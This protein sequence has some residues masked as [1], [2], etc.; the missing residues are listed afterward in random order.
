[1]S[2]PQVTWDTAPQPKPEVTWDESP[3]PTLKPSHE[4]ID[5]SK[6]STALIASHMTGIP[7]SMAYQNHDQVQAEFA[8]HNIDA[9]LPATIANDIKVGSENSIFGLAYR[10]RL[11]EHLQAPGQFDE[12][13]AGLSTMVLDLPV[14][15]AGMT[16]GAAVGNVP[17]AAMGTFAV[18]AAIR[19]SLM[20]Q[21]E[22]G[23]IKSF[24]D[25][26]ERTL[27]VSYESTKGA[28]TGLVME[29]SGGATVPLKAALGPAAPAFTAVAKVAQQSA[30]LELLTSLEEG[31]MPT[32]VGIAKNA[33]LMGTLGLVAHGIPIAA[34]RGKQALMD[35]YAKDGTTPEQSATKLQA[36][37]SVK[38]DMP[39]GLKPAIMLKASD[40]SD[41]VITGEHNTHSDL[42]EAM[43]GQRPV[44]IDELEADP[45]LAD[46][47]LSQPRTHVQQVIDRAYEIKSQAGEPLPPKS[48]FKSGRGFTNAAGDYLPRNQAK[49]LVKE[50]EPDVYAKW[51]EITGDDKAEFHSADYKEARERVAA[52]KVAEGEP[53]VPKELA[54]F[55]A[56]I[57]PELNDIK[58]SNK[59]DGYGKEV[60][61][62]L[63]VGPRNSIRSNAEQ[64]VGR[65][66]ELVPDST[67]QQAISFMRD[68]RDDPGVLRTEI[69]DISKGDNEKLK[70]MIPA[71]EKALNPTPEMLEAD[72]QITDYFTTANMLRSKY[73]K[74]GSSIDP[75]RYSP[76]NF[77]KVED[78]EAGVPSGSSARFS[79]RSPHDIRREYL[80]L[81]DPLKSGEIV[82]KTF[83]AFDE[84]SIYGDRLGK[85]IA[86]NG[87]MLELKNSELGKNGVAGQVPPELR[88][89]LAD[90]N[91]LSSKELDELGG[92]PKDWVDLPGTGKTIVSNGKQFQMGFK[93]PPKIAKA[94]EPIMEG[95]TLSNVEAWR[96]AKLA[97]GYI[98]AVE[99]GLSP[100]HLRAM[101]LSF[102]N[103]AGLDAYRM[104]MVTDN[105]SPEFEGME[106]YY[107]LRGLET[108]K[109]QIP[110][111]AYRGLDM[112]APK[113]R[114]ELLNK[115]REGYEPIDKAF[116][117]ITKLTFE[118]VQRKFKVIDMAVRDAAWLADHKGATE[119]EH[120]I[121]MRSM[122]K[123]VNS[124]Y[125]GLNWD[126]MGVS[127]NY[128]A[129]AR[130]ILLAPDWTFSNL[131]GLKYG[132]TEWGTPAG[133]ASRMFMLKSFIT[134]VALT[135]AMS[136]FVSG[137]YSDQWDKVYLGDDSKGKKMYS[138]MF[139][140]G[141]PKDAWGL[142]T[143]NINDGFPAGIVTWGMNKAAPLAGTLVREAMNKDWEGKPIRNKADTALGKTGKNIEFAA[144]NL[145]PAPFVIKDIAKGLIN[146]DKDITYKDFLAA[147][148]GASVYHETPKKQK[149]TLP[150]L[151]K[152]KLKQGTR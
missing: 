98:K 40:G 35:V 12:F 150:K 119:A 70:T 109:T 83:N 94:V 16:G 60:L 1:M 100:F 18:P 31:R 45:K 57:R 38:P 62:T 66:R 128:Q 123:E 124:V 20:L 89:Q 74:A 4:P 93:V 14:Y 122:A 10:Q 34:G 147:V 90:T 61:R 37:P 127:R 48:Q 51:A 47:V 52:I 63:L 152:K 129:V 126:V 22:R 104:A 9:P 95:D 64:L 3:T 136:K 82:A 53:G 125:G 115:V 81:L 17:G 105:N 33:A 28:A 113:S 68:Y 111:E 151:Q 36:Q 79:K 121:A 21:I 84:L 65:L 149:L 99:L 116:K 88:A 117:S 110:R 144:E 27:A 130:M 78:E 2:S 43:T 118:V 49:S 58:A 69:D 56:G 5:Y 112:D 19:K 77:M 137:Q 143:H 73:T 41:Q 59:S 133:N 114:N 102:V 134:G 106:R 29:A 86:N 131:A 55:Y 39:E 141:L 46:K 23:N 97:Q 146:P 13:V 44:T 92:I 6:M 148:I 26:M 72:K 87:F 132:L 15:I 138:S 75:A 108:T 140:A 25:L 11:P 103:N 101:T 32:A 30:A 24:R 8:K 96:I 145:V 120:E 50:N 71:M 107:A 91:I 135:Q 67:D 85:S 142:Y 139:L 76:R 42:A 54:D 80:H 7:A